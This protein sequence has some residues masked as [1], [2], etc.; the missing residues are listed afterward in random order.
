LTATIAV[1]FLRARD[2]AP[3]GTPDW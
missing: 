3:K 1:V 2:A